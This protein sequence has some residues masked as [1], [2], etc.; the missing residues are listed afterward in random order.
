MAESLQ[1]K[2]VRKGKDHF[3]LKREAR[4][5]AVSYHRTKARK[6]V[7]ET[8]KAYKVKKKAVRKARRAHQE[9]RKIGDQKTIKAT[10]DKLDQVKK[11]AKKARH[12]N[13]LMVKRNGGSRKKKLAIKAHQT[14]RRLGEAAMAEHD[15]LGD[16]ASAR[17]KIRRAQA[18]LRLAKRASRHVGRIG[19]SSVQMTAKAGNSLANRTFNFARGKG[20]KRTALDSRWETKL[21]RRY[22]QLK[23]RLVK[24]KLTKGVK[25]TAKAGKWVTTPIRSILKNPL[26]LKSYLILFC[27]LCILAVFGGGS[28]MSQDEFELTKTWLKMTKY[29]R[30]FST[31]EVDYYTNIDDVVHFMNYRYGDFAL[32]DKVDPE[33]KA[34]SN[35]DY[36]LFLGEIWK[37]LNEDKEHLKSMVDLYGSKDSPMPDLVLSKDELEDYEELLE[38]AKEVGRYLPYQEL[39]NPFSPDDEDGKPLVIAKRFGYTSVDEVYEGI[40]LTASGGHN[41]YAVMTGEVVVDGEDLIIKTDDSEFI[42]KGIASIR[43]QTGDEVEAGDLIGQVGSSDGLEVFYKKKKDN[44]LKTWAYVNPAFYFTHVSYTQATTLKSPIGLDG[45][46][47]SRIQTAYDLMKKHEPNITYEGVAATLGNFWTESNIT[48]KRAE[49]DYLAPPVGASEGSWDNPAWLALGGMAIYGQYENIIHRGLGL[50]QWT[51]TQDGSIRHTLL[52]DFAKAKGKKWYD[53]ELQIDFMFNGDAPY[54]RQTLRDILTSTGDVN[55]LT[56]R[57]L[58]EWEGNSGD[59]L[60]QRQANAQ[61]AYQFLKN[62]ISPS[63]GGF[64]HPFKVPYVVLQPYGYTAWSTGAGYFLYASSGGKHTGVDIQAY[65]Y[66]TS[67]IPIYSM[68][69]GTVHSVF[70]SDLGGNAIVIETDFGGYLYYGHNKYAATIPVGSKVTKGQQI[71]VL[72]NSGMTD[73][74]HIHLE[75]SSQPIYGSG[76][77]DRDPSFLF[78]KEGSLAQSQ[79]ITP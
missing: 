19:K 69:N 23:N 56:H 3:A 77:Y 36:G 48:A 33:P 52:L 43:Y 61:Q 65:G 67:D 8:S 62:P 31:D 25:T 59:K 68:T 53:L 15:T 79:V 73:I 38:T 13:S 39:D 24:N 55:A 2:V 32:G 60:A 54:Y 51:D 20:F 47:A 71:A 18:D 22:R 37:G 50:G 78:Q 14:N 72:G 74:Y 26:S 5:E 29:D 63:A 9:A 6:A 76:A 40:T 41:L 1:S 16:V 12:V 27:L 58:V 57:F 17:Q 70:Y 35:I 75:Y 66:E 49:G 4:R 21:A 42:Y 7:K 46:I 64:V 10:R 11:E 34:Y 28:G 30:D 44:L 45:D